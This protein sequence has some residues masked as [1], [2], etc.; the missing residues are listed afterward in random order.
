M[1]AAGLALTVS[2]GALS[3]DDNLHLATLLALPLVVV[4]GKIQRVYDRDELILNKSTID[5]APGSFSLRPSTPCSSTS[6]M[7]SCSP[8]RS[9]LARWSRSG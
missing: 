6:Y 5:E 9:A 1:A 2:V 8:G 4:A 3:P 7:S